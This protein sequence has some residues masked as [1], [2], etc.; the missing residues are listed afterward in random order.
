MIRRPPRST[1][2]VTLFPSTTLFRYGAEFDHPGPRLRE[3]VGAIRSA[4][5]AFRGDRLHHEGEFWKLSLLPAMW[6]PGAIAVPDPPIDLAAV[7]PWMLR[8]A[9]EV[10]DRSEEHTSELQSLMRIS[11][12]VFC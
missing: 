5:S 9:G 6:S 7:N 8:M 1:L 4:F 10:A 2:T 11:Y 3:Y 12:A